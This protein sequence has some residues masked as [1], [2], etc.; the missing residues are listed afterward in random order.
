MIGLCSLDSRR[1]SRRARQS[2]MAHLGTV[3]VVALDSIQDGYK[4]CDEA[5]GKNKTEFCT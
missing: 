2:A 4:N 5:A 1:A 3:P